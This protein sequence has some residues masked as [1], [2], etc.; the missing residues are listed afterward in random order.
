[1]SH[2]AVMDSFF[3]MERWDCKNI[4]ML[5]VVRILPSRGRDKQESLGYPFLGS[6]QISYLLVP[7][8]LTT[9]EYSWLR[10]LFS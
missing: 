4:R 6:Q 8:P 3:L 10:F 1:M 5:V 9:E 7:F 2:E